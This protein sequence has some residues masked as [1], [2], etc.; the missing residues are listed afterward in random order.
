MTTLPSFDELVSTLGVDATTRPRR[1]SITSRRSSRSISPNVFYSPISSPTRSKSSE[2]LREPAQRHSSRYSPY[3]PSQ[4]VR[5]SM[6]SY[7]DY[8]LT[9]VR[10]RSSRRG[11][12][13]SVSSSSSSSDSDY[14][15]HV[16]NHCMF[17]ISA[18][19]YHL[20]GL[21]PPITT[22]SPTSKRKQ[23]HRKRLRLIHRPISE[24]T[25]LHL[26]T[27]QN[28][29]RISNITRVHHLPRFITLL[30]LLL[31]NAVHA[32]HPSHRAIR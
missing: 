7:Y 32:P 19:T 24:Y 15:V 31:P 17:T 11:S 8:V 2:S 26:R 29:R 13:S 3:S 4:I 22:S 16:S 5:P 25:H 18:V 9:F 1:D 14:K 12:L 20:S 6:S 21:G 23:A 30:N 28:P 10:Q 27:P